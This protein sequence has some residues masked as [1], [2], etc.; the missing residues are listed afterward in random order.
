MV[1]ILDK[2]LLADYKGGVHLENLCNSNCLIHFRVYL[3]ME[4][5][6]A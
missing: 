2:W 5:Q 3:I 1:L 4:A 6:F